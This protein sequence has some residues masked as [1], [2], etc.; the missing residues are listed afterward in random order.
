MLVQTY[1]ILL[2]L[3][4]AGCT[5][6]SIRARVVCLEYFISHPASS[7]GLL[8][9]CLTTCGLI[10]FGLPRPC[11]LSSEMCGSFAPAGVPVCEIK[12][13]SSALRGR[14][15][16]SS[17][18]NSLSVV[19]A[20]LAL[21]NAKGPSCAKLAWIVQPYVCTTCGVRDVCLSR[22]RGA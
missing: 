5:L 12:H 10:S 1:L 9:P 11:A 7:I 16:R 14:G 22:R 18:A 19:P 15:E 8:R 20:C 3:S 2:P 21:Y 4:D 17:K 13:V 6:S